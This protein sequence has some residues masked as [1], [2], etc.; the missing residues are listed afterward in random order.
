MN[1]VSDKGQKALN[2]ILNSRNADEIAYAYYRIKEIVTSGSIDDHLT[3]V[4]EKY[5]ERASEL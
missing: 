3:R 2:T 5:I 4:G 1:R